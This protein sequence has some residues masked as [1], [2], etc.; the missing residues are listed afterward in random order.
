M[1]KFRDDI[2]SLNTY[3]S[4]KVVLDKLNTYTKYV[5]AGNIDPNCPRDVWVFDIVNCTD[6]SA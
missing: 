2:S 5:V 1:G 6:P 3:D 4:P